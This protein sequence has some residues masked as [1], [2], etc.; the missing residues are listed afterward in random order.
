MHYS[1][2]LLGLREKGLCSISVFEASTLPSGGSEERDT[3][4]CGRERYIG[5]GWRERE[6]VEATGTGRGWIFLR[7]GGRRKRS[8]RV[9]R[10]FEMDSTLP[11]CPPTTLLLS[12]HPFLFFCFFFLS[13]LLL[14]LHEK[15]SP[16]WLGWI[17]FS[18][19]GEEG[20]RDDLE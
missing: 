4:A 17:S 5:K 8:D 11:S 14:S 1:W 2:W 10:N 13:P 18:V 3:Q 16:D 20:A 12:D 15:H 7:E 6:T 19:E 9:A